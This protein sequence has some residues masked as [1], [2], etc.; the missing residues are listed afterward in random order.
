MALGPQRFVYLPQIRRIS[1]RG[2]YFPDR[3]VLGQ[4]LSLF[5]LK[6]EDAEFRAGLKTVMLAPEPDEPINVFVLASR[7]RQAIRTVDEDSVDEAEFR[8]YTPEGAVSFINAL[9]SINMRRV[10]SIAELPA[11]MQPYVTSE[12]QK[13]E[14]DRERGDD[15]GGDDDDDDLGPLI[16]TE[17]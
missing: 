10:K 15:D 8:H 11:F 3:E 6:S 5:L 12:V 4:M 7:R 14:E 2:V 17:I 1:V 13:A 9:D 16:I